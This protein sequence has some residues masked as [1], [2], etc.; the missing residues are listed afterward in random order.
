MKIVL[1]RGAKHVKYRNYYL[2]T[3]F[4]FNFL[5]IVFILF[6][7][8]KQNSFYQSSPKLLHSIFIECVYTLVTY[9]KKKKKKNTKHVYV[10]D[11]D[12]CNCAMQF[13]LILSQNIYIYIFFL[14]FH[15]FFFL[16]LLFFFFLYIYI[17]W[18]RFKVVFGNSKSLPF[19]PINLNPYIRLDY[20]IVRKLTKDGFLILLCLYLLR[21][22]FS[23]LRVLFC[24]F[25][26]LFFFGINI[27]P[28]IDVEGLFSI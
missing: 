6:W 19:I 26:F 18:Y 11:W 4:K 13:T 3:N 12:Q 10:R 16:L 22:F 17:Q 21:F 25:Y 5:K 15:F 27:F 28:V 20:F 23:S 9:F 8:Q 7:K 24:D 14:H 1:K 2:K